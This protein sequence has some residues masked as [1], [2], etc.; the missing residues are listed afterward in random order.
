MK[1]LLFGGWHQNGGPSNV[2][3]THVM[4]AD[5]RLVFLKIQNRVFRRFE[6]LFRIF[7]CEKILFSGSLPLKYEWFICK[8]LHK[9]VFYYMH[10]DLRYENVINKQGHTEKAFTI[11]D[12]VL[13][14]SHKI[15]AVSERYAQWLKKRYPQYADKITFVNNGLNIERRKMVVKEPMTIAVSGGNRQIKNNDIVCE[16]V[17]VLRERGYDIK[18]YVFGRHYPDNADLDKYPFAVRMGQMDKDEYYAHLDRISLYVVNSELES[19]G[20]I[21]GDAINCNCS[22]LVS[23]I[24]GARSI[25]TMADEDMVY[26]SHNI[27]EVASKILNLLEHPNNERLYNTIDIE[28][29]SEKS[30]YNNLMNVIFNE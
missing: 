14:Y 24:V 20:L 25:M 29:V 4:S 13:K 26:D 6:R 15:I 30:A 23:E 12:D 2:N 11:F 22:L 16:A 17:S 21:V 3:K 7:T 10:G 28:G 19:F 8:L 9:D 18:V 5:D 27:E 1:V